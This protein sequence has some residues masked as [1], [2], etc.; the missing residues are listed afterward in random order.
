MDPRKTKQN[1]NKNKNKTEKNKQTN[2]QNKKQTNKNK[3]K[4]KQNK[5]KRFLV[6]GLIPIAFIQFKDLLT[7]PKGLLLMWI[8]SLVPKCERHNTF[9]IYRALEKGDLFKKRK[10]SGPSAP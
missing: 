7:S 3:N 5:K 10:M 8:S 9:I 6:V 2:K 4:T 1:K